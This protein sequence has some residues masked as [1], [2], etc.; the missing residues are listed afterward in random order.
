MLFPW[1]MARAVYEDM[2]ADEP[3]GALGPIGPANFAA[4]GYN[5]SLD[6]RRVL[7]GPIFAPRANITVALEAEIFL[8]HE[9]A[10]L[11]GKDNPD[12][13]WVRLDFAF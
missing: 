2:N 1:L 4:A 11:V 5:G 9:G 13:F 7:V 12:N 8:E 6:A 10:D 3:G